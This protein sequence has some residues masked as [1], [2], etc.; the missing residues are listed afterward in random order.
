MNLKLQI[1]N[2]GQS[3]VAL[4]KGVEPYIN[5]YEILETLWDLIS[6]RELPNYKL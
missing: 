4:K 2:E 1:L 6:T 5:Q 3:D